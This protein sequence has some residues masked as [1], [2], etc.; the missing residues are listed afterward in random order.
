MVGLGCPF[1]A[2]PRRHHGR[3][4]LKHFMCALV[5]EFS[6]H[7][8]GGGEL[9]KT[10]VSEVCLFEVETPIGNFVRNTTPLLMGKIVSCCAAMI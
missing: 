8:E 10:A 2:C 1:E 9:C 6:Y 7:F 5:G 3:L 4:L